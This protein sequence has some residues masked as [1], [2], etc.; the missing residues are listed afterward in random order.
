LKTANFG[1]GNL[2]AA[3]ATCGAAMPREVAVR[4]FPEDVEIVYVDH[5]AQR[6]SMQRQGY[7]SVGAG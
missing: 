4:S 2:Q 1:P 6:M 5:I 7:L 3:R